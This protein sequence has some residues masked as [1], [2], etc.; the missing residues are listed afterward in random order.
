MRI[1]DWSSDVCSSDLA[2]GPFD[3]RVDAQ[4]ADSRALSGRLLRLLIERPLHVFADHLVGVIA[5]C[6]ECLHCLTGPWRIAE[7]D[8]QVAQPSRI[9]GATQRHALG[10]LRPFGFGPCEQLDEFW[11]KIGRAHVLTPVHN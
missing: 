3:R 5:S 8:R 6:R 4:A 10:A 2:T 7:C 9:T 1:S 11:C